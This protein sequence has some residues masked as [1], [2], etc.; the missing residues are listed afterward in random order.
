[1]SRKGGAVLRHLLA[2]VLLPVVVTTVVP[3][4]LMS[5][6]AAL[7]SRWAPGAIGGVAGRVGGALLL[8]GA[9]A[10]FV[11]CVSLFARVGRGTLAPWDPT[12]NLV[13][14][15]PYRY[16]RNPMISAVAGVLLGEALLAGSWVLGIWFVVFLAIN[17]TYFILS[18]E[19]GLEARFGATYSAYKSRVPRWLPRWRSSP[20]PRSSVED[21]SSRGTST[22][23]RAS[24]RA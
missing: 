15:G 14:V 6:F 4:W 17:Q 19:P 2:I 24:P 20:P 7:D 22:A 10:L 9:L 11:W 3:W 16:V 1:M 18:E 23:K 12:T 21:C 13:D 8:L 5:R